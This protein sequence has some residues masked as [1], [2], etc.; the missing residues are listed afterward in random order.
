VEEFPELLQA[1]NASPQPKHGV[2]HHILKDSRLVFAKARP[3][4]PAKP[5]ITEEEFAALEKAGIV[6]PVL[7]IRIRNNP[8]NLARSKSESKKKFGLD[9]DSDSDTDVE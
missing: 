8:N 4:E 9:T 1:V 3:L 6:L 5:R 2:E 7:W